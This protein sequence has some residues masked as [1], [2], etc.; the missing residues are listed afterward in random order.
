MGASAEK[1]YAAYRIVAVSPKSQ[2]VQ[3]PIEPMLDFLVYP[4]LPELFATLTRAKELLGQDPHAT[5]Q[6]GF[7]NMASQISWSAKL[8]LSWWRD[9]ADLGLDYRPEDCVSAH[10][11]VIRVL[12][13][14]VDSPLHRA[15]LRSGS[16]YII[17]T[18]DRTFE[19]LEDFVSFIKENDQKQVELFVYNAEDE[20][21]RK[22]VLVPNSAWGG[23]GS[24]GG[25]LGSGH[26]HSIPVRKTKKKGLEKTEE[27]KQPPAKEES[28][29]PEEKKSEP[30][31]KEEPKSEPATATAPTPSPTT[32]PAPSEV[33]GVDASDILIGPKPEQKQSPTQAPP[34][35]TDVII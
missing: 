17:G 10:S 18:K 25:E 5:L 15:G 16:D 3:L 20:T 22:T 13:I 4:P 29:F 9:S 1:S 8:P 23:A 35:K 31:P 33:L 26:L 28:K 7:F 14:Y 27:K 32:V 24:L 19:D 6:L 34:A 12:S 11:K 21:A 30:L 2:I